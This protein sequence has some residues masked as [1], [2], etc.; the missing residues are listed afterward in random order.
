MESVGYLQHIMPHFR[1]LEVLTLPPDCFDREGHFFALKC[2]R[3]A[4]VSLV[5]YDPRE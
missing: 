2:A 5:K 4:S 1:N 3:L